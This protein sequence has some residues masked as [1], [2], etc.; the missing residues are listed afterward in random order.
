MPILRLKIRRSDATPD[1][2]LAVLREH[3]CGREKSFFELVRERLVDID[4]DEAVSQ[5]VD[6]KVR[7]ARSKVPIIAVREA[8][9]K[10]Y[11]ISPEK[12]PMAEAVLQVLRD[13]GEYLPLSLRAIHYRMLD[14]EFFRNAKAETAYCNDLASYKDLSKIVTRMRLAGEIDFDDLEDETRPVVLWDCWRN[15]ADFISREADRFLT[16]YARDL[17]QSQTKHFEIVVEKLT[18]QSFVQPVAARYCIPVVIGH[19]ATAAHRR[20]R[21]STIAEAVQ[22]VRQADPVLAVSGGL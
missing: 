4:P 9:M 20:Q 3:N 14:K 7:R 11:K 22:G 10:R 18:V 5:V 21:L 15:A 2:W 16:R 17:M 12:R 6:D 1:Q 19:A 8:R 13:L